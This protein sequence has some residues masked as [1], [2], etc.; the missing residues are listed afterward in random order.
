MKNKIFNFVIENLGFDDCA[1]T[2]PFLTPDQI[3]EYQKFIQE[4]K[5][6]KLTYLKNHLP[7]KKNPE[8][9]LPKVQTAI[10]VIKNYFNLGKYTNPRI[11]RYAI[12]QDYHKIIGRKL[13]ELSE[14][15]TTSFSLENNPSKC[16]WGVDS[17]PIAEKCLAI[18]AGIGFLGKNQL[19]IKPGLGSFFVIGVIYTDLKLPFDL[20]KK[21]KSACC[22]CRKCLDHCPTSALK[23]N[24]NGSVELII[25]KCISYQTIYQK[26][27]L[28]WQKGCDI[29]QEICPYNKNIPITDWSEF[30][31][32]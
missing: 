14:F 21:Y 27:Y 16:Y 7:F 32:N 9:L 4:K 23:E 8:L 13:I 31:A 17:R 29:C 25:E 28:D 15:I 10:V 19:V 6:A 18:N 24:K 11:A 26:P 2:S 22:N 12:N 30:K 3:Q 1:F 5:F 20:P